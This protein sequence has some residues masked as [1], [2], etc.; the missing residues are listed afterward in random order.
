MVKIPYELRMNWS[1]L[2]KE[3]I[4]AVGTSMDEQAPYSDLVKL[5][6]KQAYYYI[7]DDVNRL[8]DLG[9][10]EEDWSIGM[11]KA[12]NGVSSGQLELNEQPCEEP[13]PA[14]TMGRHKDENSDSLPY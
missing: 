7:K 11:A 3:L 12:V 6:A 5:L 2:Q 14:Y 4:W 9:R 10:D 1:R 13:F 8:R